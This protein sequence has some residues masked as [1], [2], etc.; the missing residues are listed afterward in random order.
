MAEP[1]RRDVL[2]SRAPVL[3]LAPEAPPAAPPPAPV[4]PPAAARLDRVA[5]RGKLGAGALG[6]L[7]LVAGGVTVADELGRPPARV[8]AAAPVASVAPADCLRSWN[9][10]AN[11]AARAGAKLGAGTRVRVARVDALPG[12]LLRGRP[13]AVS[14]TAPGAGTTRVWVDGVEGRAGFLDVSGYPAARRYRAPRGAAAA[15]ATV[16]ADGTLAPR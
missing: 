7:A 9:G 5:R 13:C 4:A 10:P 1:V 14:V 16:G 8:A 12:T 15:N 6:V 3:R 2:P 11:D